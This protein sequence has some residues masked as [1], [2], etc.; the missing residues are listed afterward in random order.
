MQ[1]STYAE[2]PVEEDDIPAID[3][4]SDRIYVESELDKRL[5]LDPGRA[6]EPLAH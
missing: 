5:H 3:D 1:G 6:T 4:T 2:A